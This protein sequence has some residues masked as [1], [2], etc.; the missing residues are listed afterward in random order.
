MFITSSYITLSVADEDHSV[1]DCLI[2]TV[3]THVNK[4]KHLTAYDCMY[5]LQDLWKPF[6]GD[7]C[8]TLLRKPKIFIIQ[9]SEFIF[10]IFDHVAL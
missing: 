8:L 2:V 10:V 9:V 3:L 4:S 6:A 7:K 1:A 5:Q